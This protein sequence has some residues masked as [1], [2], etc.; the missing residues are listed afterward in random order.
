MLRVQFED[1]LGVVDYGFDLCFA[2]DDPFV[3]EQP[4]DVARF[5]V[6]YQVRIESR[7]RFADA[8]P[9]SGYD[10]PADPSL[11]HRA[12]ER[13]QVAGE[14]LGAAARRGLPSIA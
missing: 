2:P 4:L 1:R 13:L 14:I 11:K 3:A 7:E 6:G 8:S 9:F 10:P 12:A 5:E